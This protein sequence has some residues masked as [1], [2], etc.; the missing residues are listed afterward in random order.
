ML[1][2]TVR[3]S[4]P[5]SPLRFLDT[6]GGAVGERDADH[7]RER[8]TNRSPSD[9]EASSSDSPDLPTVQELL[10]EHSNRSSAATATQSQQQL[11]ASQGGDS[12]ERT[13]Q[14]PP[15]A[16]LRSAGS[17]EAAA[18]F[19]CLEEESRGSQG[20]ESEEGEDDEYI[21]TN[22]ASA[23]GEARKTS[24]PERDDRLLK[25]G[26]AQNQRGSR[27]D[28]PKLVVF[29]NGASEKQRTRGALERRWYSLTTG[30]TRR[31]ATE[32]TKDVR[33]SCKRKRTSEARPARSRWRDEEVLVLRKILAQPSDLL[34]SQSMIN[35]DFYRALPRSERSRKALREKC[36][37]LRQD[38]G[39]R[40]EEEGSEDESDEREDD[41]ESGYGADDSGDVAMAQSSAVPPLASGPTAQTRSARRLLPLEESQA[42]YREANEAQTPAPYTPSGRIDFDANLDLRRTEE[43]QP[44]VL[45]PAAE[46]QQPQSAAI[47]AGSTATAPAVDR[48]AISATPASGSTAAAPVS[49][50]SAALLS[51]PA[52]PSATAGPS[53][54]QVPPTFS[55]TSSSKGVRIKGCFPGLEILVFSGGETRIFHHAS[56]VPVFE[57]PPLLHLRCLDGRRVRPLILSQEVSIRVGSARETAFLIEENFSV[58]LLEQP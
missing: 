21:S 11:R 35:R 16:V 42:Q 57:N 27:I 24:W 39:G 49:S 9:D 36:R 33:A 6:V 13:A 34:G 3:P 23:S 25:L 26:V 8:N 22:A 14:S 46:R 58:V 29:F 5:P 28:W 37:R 51:P 10:A 30:H 55:F 19:P 47:S 38:G 53:F 54:I 17:D 45:T 18:Q 41:E 20:P 56:A 4:R 31:F 52:T 40:D 44:P 7:A 32:A 12:L 43:A 15:P 2:S 1:P 48:N 50:S